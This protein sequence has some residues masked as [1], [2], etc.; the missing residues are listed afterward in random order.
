MHSIV[1]LWS[2]VFKHVVATTYSVFTA[3]HVGLIRAALYD[4]NAQTDL[5]E[6]LV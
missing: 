4:S 3:L 6:M 2:D 1:P 5:I